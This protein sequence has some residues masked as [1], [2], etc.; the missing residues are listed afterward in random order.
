M[1]R[2]HRRLDGFFFN[3]RF[4]N[5]VFFND[6]FRGRFWLW[7]SDNFRRKRYRREVFFLLRQ[8]LFRLCSRWFYGFR[9]GFWLNRRLNGFRLCALFFFMHH[10]FA[11]GHDVIGEF[12]RLGQGVRGLL[13]GR[14]RLRVRLN[15]RFCRRGLFCYVLFLLFGFRFCLLFLAKTQPGKKAT[16]LLFC[17]WRMHSSRLIHGAVPSSGSGY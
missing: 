14:L 4:F 6:R 10:A 1:R 12:F 5:N 13:R 16:F 11:D 7:F 3:S 17:H 15:A 2:F 8:P 9:L